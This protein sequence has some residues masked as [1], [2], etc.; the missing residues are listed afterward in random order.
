M[1]GWLATQDL[2]SARLLEPAVGRGEFLVQAAERLVDSF[3]RRGVEPKIEQ[4]RSRI[5]GLEIHAEA[6]AGARRRVVKKMASL[7]IHL[8]TAR[9][10][11]TAWIRTGDYLL[12]ETAKD[13]Y[14]H[15]VGNPP[16]VRWRKVP[17]RLRGAYEKRMPEMARGDLY[18]PFLDRT[19]EELK[20]GGRCGFVCSD[21]W[22]YA[23]YATGFRRKWLPR[24]DVDAN[25]P[26]EAAD[27]FKRDVSAYASVL[28]ASKRESA[29]GEEYGAV[30]SAKRGRSLA[31][32]GCTI[33]VGPA[34]G[35]TRAFVLEGNFVDVE[36][37]LLLPW[38]DPSEVREGRVA[39]RGR[40][41]VSMFDEDGK[42]RNLQQYPRLARHLEKY[43]SDLTE[44]YI[45]RHGA[46]WY[47][48]IDRLL[49]ADWCRPK[50]L[51]PDIAKRPRV[52]FDQRGYVPSH[53][54][55]AIFAA[56]D[57]LDRVYEALRD[58]GLAEGLD[59]V[60]PRIKNGYVRCYKRF[61]GAVRV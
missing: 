42:L 11:A 51:L 40:F 56:P 14:T 7:G 41:V 44:R 57:Q 23:A 29:K 8:N 55:Y 38:V 35:V 60:A 10:C 37:E 31:E 1:V 26:M 21:R 50:I 12:S 45:V 24:I 3:R 15:V 18:L 4:L 20:P 46:P 53:G 22:Q 43:R 5:V 2:S 34:L 52:A 32:L 17:S 59:G 16:Y 13:Q 36:P 19:L 54:V 30:A 61:L 48:T 27:A 49:A 9:A 58:G 28:I 33:R 47:R 25:W 39:W 6:S